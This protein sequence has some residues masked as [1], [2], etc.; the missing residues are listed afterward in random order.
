MTFDACRDD[1]EVMMRAGES[2]GT[3][4]ATIDG[5]RITE[6][7]GAA[8]WLLAWSMRNGIAHPQDASTIL[9]RQSIPD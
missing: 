1:V 2:L 4:E 9:E 6:D 5:A 8:L 7:E 3:V